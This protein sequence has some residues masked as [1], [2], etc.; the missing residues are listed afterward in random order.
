[1]TNIACTEDSGF[2]MTGTVINDDQIHIN[3]R[4]NKDDCEDVNISYVFT[5]EEAIALRDALSELIGD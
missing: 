5:T 4:Y 2:D 3:F 1:M